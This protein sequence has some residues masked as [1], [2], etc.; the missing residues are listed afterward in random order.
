MSDRHDE[1][2]GWRRATSLEGLTVGAILAGL[3][4]TALVAAFGLIVDTGVDGSE[5]GPSADATGASTTTA[6]AESESTEQELAADKGSVCPRDATYNGLHLP[7]V[8]DDQVTAPLGSDVSVSFH[9]NRREGS[10]PDAR[11]EILVLDGSCQISLVRVL[12]PGDTTD[13]SFPAG[14]TVII[15][16]LGGGFFD[17]ASV[18]AD[19]AI[20]SVTIG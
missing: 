12:H 19:E 3:I 6:S 1:P 18:V 5:K 9:M 10:A 4:T 8:Y 11:T 2:K 20:P 16:K 15:S 7:R 17:T 14:E 13:L